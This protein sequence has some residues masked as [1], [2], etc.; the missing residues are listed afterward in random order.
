MAGRKGIHYDWT[1]LCLALC[2]SKSDKCG[3]SSGKH[4]GCEQCV[5]GRVGLI[6]P[7]ALHTWGYSLP[8]VI[9]FQVSKVPE[10]KALP[11]AL[12]A[13]VGKDVEREGVLC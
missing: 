10:G 6:P 3:C 7:R 9:I 12:S 8:V 13:S 4:H 5:H 11:V 1:E 2:E